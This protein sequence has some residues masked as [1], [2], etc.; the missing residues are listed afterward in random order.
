MENWDG[1]GGDW[2]IFFIYF[3][4]LGQS[5]FFYMEHARLF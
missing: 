5:F 3:F 1:M 2:L 4:I